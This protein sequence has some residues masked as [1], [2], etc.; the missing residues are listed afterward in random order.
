MRH[1][2]ALALP[3]LVL[4][5]LAAPARG[6]GLPVAGVNAG[7]EGVAAGAVRY[8]TLDGARGTVVAAVGRQGGRVLRSRALSGRFTIPAVAYDGSP[9]GLAA[10]GRTLVLIRPR[11]SFPQRRTS[12]AV[13]DTRTLAVRRFL[14]LRGDFSFDAVAPDGRSMFLI[15]YLSP[16]DPTRYEVRSYDLAAGRLEPAPVVDPRE[17]GEKMRGFPVSR[18]VSRD[19]RWAY[20]LYDGAG[21]AP[22]VHALDTVGRTARCVDMAMLNGRS[23]LFAL[24]LRAGAGRLDVVAR[25]RPV[26]TVDARTFRAGPPPAAAPVRTDS[27]PRAPWW[28]WVSAVAVLLA[29]VLLA[30]GA[31]RR[32]RVTAA[33]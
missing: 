19:G 33:A 3:L 24:R 22:F 4:L 32:R 23:D 5:A 11:T 16:T 18:A 29:T 1:L 21:H 30:G 8:V 28:P 15:H 2:T 26:A 13:L 20:T 7:P 9:S 14:R 17:R 25:G 10:A 27:H 6:D 31:L 12:L